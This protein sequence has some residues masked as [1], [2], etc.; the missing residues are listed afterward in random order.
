MPRI[1]FAALVAALF[2]PAVASAKVPD[3]RFSTVDPILY[4]SPSGDRAYKVV[5]RDVG[6]APIQGRVV[7]LDFSGSSLRLYTTPE[8][9]TTINAANKTIA[10][11]SGP[12][13][14][15][16]FHPR[17]GGACNTADVMVQAEGVVLTFVPARSTDIDAAHGCVDL[18][19]FVRFAGP[20]LASDAAHAELDF[21]GSG[22][23][24]ALGDFV[25]F[26]RD[27]LAG[28]KGEY[29]P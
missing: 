15:A 25:I 18:Q 29:C 12:D 24:P 10:R 5:I 11:F 2:L 19:D 1:A 17:F 7:I 3:P 9:G 8:A 26:A 4:G 16:V 14:S 6:Y 20:Y 23:A 27:L 28:T 13:G 22:G 21:D